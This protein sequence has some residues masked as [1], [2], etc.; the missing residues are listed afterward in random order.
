MDGTNAFAMLV[1]AQDVEDAADEGDRGWQRAVADGEVVVLDLGR[2]DTKSGAAFGEVRVV[3]KE[4]VGFGE[5]DEGAY[6]GEQQRV[7]LLL[8]VLT[9][10][11][12]RRE[13]AVRELARDEVRRRPIRIWYGARQGADVGRLVVRGR[14]GGR[15]RG[16]E[17]G[18]AAA[19]RQRLSEH[20]RRASFANDA[21]FCRESGCG[22]CCGRRGRGAKIGGRR[23]DGAPYLYRATAQNVLDRGQT[24]TA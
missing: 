14:R 1:V 18:R 11:V 5:V 8:G 9:R 10:G 13:R 17:G 22:G 24:P 6:T 21:H 4:L 16:G 15:R 20:D 12:R 23:R 19:R 2:V 7:E 3:R